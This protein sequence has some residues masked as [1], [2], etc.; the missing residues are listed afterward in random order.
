MSAGLAKNHVR[1]ALR[2]I[3]DHEPSKR[4]VARLWEY[5]GSACVYCG[6]K[7]ERDARHGHIDHLVHDGPNHISNRVLACPTCNG[8]EKLDKP[9]LGFLKN[10]TGSRKVFKER[11]RKIDDWVEAEKPSA[12]AGYDKGLLKREVE[13][14]VRVFDRAVAKLRRT[15]AEA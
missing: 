8:D 12:P 10:K 5:F 9:W 15:R 2:A 14:V 7:L 13:A 11:R 6:R 3:V 1:R 4:D